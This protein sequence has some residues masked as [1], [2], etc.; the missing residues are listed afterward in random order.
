MGLIIEQVEI[1]GTVKSIKVSA[2]IDSG[3]EGGAIRSHAEGGERVSNH[4]IRCISCNTSLCQ[5]EETEDWYCP[6]CRKRTREIEIELP[7]ME[8]L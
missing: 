3:A 5:L 4:R 1:K 6:T 7:N 8:I 2:L